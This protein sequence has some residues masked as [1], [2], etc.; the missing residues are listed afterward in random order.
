M[1]EY[2]KAVMP[3]RMTKELH[4]WLKDNIK[5]KPINDFVVSLIEQYR[6]NLKPESEREIG[7]E[8]ELDPEVEWGQLQMHLSEEIKRLLTV[9]EAIV[10]QRDF[11]Q[12]KD[13]F[14]TM[15]TT[16]D[17]DSGAGGSYDVNVFSP[18][19]KQYHDDL[20]KLRNS[21]FEEFCKFFVAL[22]L[23]LSAER[24]REISAWCHGDSNEVIF[25]EVTRG[26]IYSKLPKDKPLSVK[27]IASK[28]G[29]S[30]HDAYDNIVPWILKE[31]WKFQAER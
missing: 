22:D 17:P 15:E 21:N 6:Q 16:L 24:K 27:F 14:F 13:C 18:E 9:R 3:L 19:A 10:K 1:T 20:E 31:G 23:K 8:P 4:A 25:K 7:E 26:D 30:Y 2:K 28:L 12:F 11:K 29:L 5:D